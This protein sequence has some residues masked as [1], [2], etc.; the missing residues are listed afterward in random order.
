MSQ[1]FLSPPI[2]LVLIAF[3]LIVLYIRRQVKMSSNPN[4]DRKN[5]LHGQW[6][7][8]IYDQKDWR[9]EVNGSTL[10]LLVYPSRSV[11]KIEADR[12]WAV[13]RIKAQVRQFNMTSPNF[14]DVS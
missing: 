14:P 7:I 1:A 12:L 6:G 4:H 10:E 2:I 3:L 11:A 9:Y 13:H 5:D 8:W